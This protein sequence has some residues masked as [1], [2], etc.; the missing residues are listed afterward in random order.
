MQ[1]GGF[2]RARKGKLQ[3]LEKGAVPGVDSRSPDVLITPLKRNAAVGVKKKNE[4]KGNGGSRP[5]A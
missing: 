2:A 3:R 5:A 1:K 4:P